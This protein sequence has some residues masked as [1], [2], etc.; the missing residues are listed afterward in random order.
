MKQTALDSLALQR[1]LSLAQELGIALPITEE[2]HLW[3]LKVAWCIQVHV[4]LQWWPVVAA[5]AGIP[6][7]ME[8]PAPWEPEWVCASFVQGPC[9][10]RVEG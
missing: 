4:N 6:E 7:D 1:L 3:S 8:E 2:D 10:S 5:C 9:G